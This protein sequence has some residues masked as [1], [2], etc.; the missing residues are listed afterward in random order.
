MRPDA[1]QIVI[2][3]RNRKAPKCCHTCDWYDK[4]G[5][6]Q[7]YKQTPPISYAESLDVCESWL[8]EIPF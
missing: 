8:E 1:P 2:E 5:H 4:E 3:W 6:C 7:F